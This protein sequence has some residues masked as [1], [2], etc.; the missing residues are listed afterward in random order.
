VRGGQPLRT[1]GIEVARLHEFKK[2]SG[3]PL[4]IPAIDLI[5]IGAGGGSIARVDARGVIQVGPESAGADPGP[6]CYG[7]G[8]KR[9]TLTDANLVL[10]YLDSASF[11]GGRMALDRD[12]AAQAIMADVARP[13]GLTLTRAAAGVHEVVNETVA[14]A[15]RVHAAEQGVDYRRCSMVAFGG[16][17]P[18]HATAVARRL[19]IPRVVFPM[20]AGVMSAIG[21]LIC[22]L[23]FATA[24]SHLKALDDLGGEEAEAVFA[25]LERQALA[26]L[27]D[28][29]IAAGRCRITRTL[30]LRYRGQSHEIDVPL[31]E[32]VGGAG[33]VAALPGLFA[34]RYAAVFARALLEETLEVVTWKVEAAFDDAPRLATMAA[35]AGSAAAT[36]RRRL[37]HAAKAGTLVECPVHHRGDLAAGAEILGPA[38]IE[39]AESTCVLGP[40]D[41]GRIDTAANLL[42]T[43]AGGEG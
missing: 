12:A 34:A 32:G 41:V 19:R 9:A 6:A 10:G 35:P 15:F 3:L 30:G 17:G 11:L 16:S 25:A 21:L 24:R 36:P 28:A 40:G 2:G 33:L 37:V 31:P 27:A 20:G 39:E 8:G 42:V 23:A 22:P 4:R 38:L 7:R 14:R 18:I 5:E 43:V 29:G 1:H 13:L 26:P